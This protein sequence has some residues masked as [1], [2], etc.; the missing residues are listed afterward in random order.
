MPADRFSDMVDNHKGG[1]GSIAQPQQGLTQRCH[2]ACIVFILIVRRIERVENN[3]VGGCGPCRCHEMIQPLCGTEEMSDSAR[4]HQ[5]MLIGGSSQGAAHDGEAIYKLWHGQ[6][7]L[8]DQN[9]ARRR[10]R[11]PDAIGTGGQR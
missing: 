8:T 5:E 4:V 6:L 9:T 2:R 1:A 3:D 7:E 11:K 10:D